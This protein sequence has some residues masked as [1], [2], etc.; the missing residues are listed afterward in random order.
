[1][2]QDKPEISCFIS[3][4]D[5]TDF[6]HRAKTS[7]ISSLVTLRVALNLLCTWTG[8]EHTGQSLADTR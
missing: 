1:M 2:L 4:I 7:R 8:S 5:G 3:S 6:E